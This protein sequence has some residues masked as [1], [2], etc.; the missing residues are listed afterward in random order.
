MA[1]GPKKPRFSKNRRWTP[2]HNEKNTGGKKRRLLDT[3][4]QRNFVYDL[5]DM[6]DGTKI[7]ENRGTLVA[8]LQNKLLTQSLNDAVEYLDR[9][10]DGNNLTEPEVERLKRLMQ[11]YTTWR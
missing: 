7:E 6:L 3:G 11:R 5:E 10:A 2:S 9:V 1:R 4:R 8:T